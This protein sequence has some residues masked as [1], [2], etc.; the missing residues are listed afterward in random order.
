MK[1]SSRAALF[2]LI[3]IVFMYATAFILAALNITNPFLQIV[4]NYVLAFAV[5]CIIYFAVTKDNIKDTLRLSPLGIVNIVFII[6]ISVCIQPT[7]YFLSSVSSLLFPNEISQYLN[8]Y[9]DTG[10]IWLII[11]LAVLP[12]VFEE[13]SY[14]GIV[15]SNYGNV[16]IKKAALATGFIFAIAHLSA[17]QF[18]YAFFLGVVFCIMVYYTKSIFSSMLSHFIINGMQVWIF[19]I[20]LLYTAQTG[21]V[22]PEVT[23]YSAVLYMGAAFVISLPVLLFVFLN[24]IKFNT[25]HNKDFYL[26]DETVLLHNPDPENE[27]KVISAPLVILTVFYIIAVIIIPL[28][29]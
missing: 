8:S 20:S 26:A 24:F 29:Y 5:P 4:A 13:I 12:A 15:F 6:L 16:N 22:S 2:A 21:T 10:T 14:R 18:L 9:S 19:K 3:L 23:P 27:E 1:L 11:A 7:I 17:Q 28:I 25:S